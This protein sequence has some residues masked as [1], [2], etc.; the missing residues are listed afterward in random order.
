M[1]A[2]G[3]H[4]EQA[5]VQLSHTRGWGRREERISCAVSNKI[6]Q[7]VKADS[8]HDTERQTEDATGE[9]GGGWVWL[10]RVGK[11]SCWERAF[12]TS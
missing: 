9:V 4:H 11:G 12:L 6:H 2:A 8:R 3:K 7:A 5:L 10:V 1:T